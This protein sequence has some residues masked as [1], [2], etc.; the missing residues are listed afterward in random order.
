MNGI[1]LHDELVWRLGEGLTVE[2]VVRSL[3]IREPFC[4]LVEACVAG[5]LVSH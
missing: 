2:L 5:C 3:A 1:L 4:H